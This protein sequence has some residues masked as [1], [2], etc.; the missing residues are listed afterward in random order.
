MAT[1]EPP[2]GGIQLRRMT[3]KIPLDQRHSDETLRATTA[4]QAFPSSTQQARSP[5]PGSPDH[6]QAG[7]QQTAEAGALE[8]E[9]EQI[10]P[11]GQN[12]ETDRYDSARQAGQG[13]GDKREDAGHNGG[14]LGRASMSVIT[15]PR[16]DTH[17]PPTSAAAQRGR[18]SL[19]STASWPDRLVAEVQTRPL[20]RLSEAR[21]APAAQQLAAHGPKRPADGAM[22][23]SPPGSAGR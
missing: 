18:L 10:D 6:G 5:L 11:F 22:L 17:R 9:A 21:F 14:A 16:A 8:H 7:G 3:V 12:I 19:K 13:D 1:T 23:R 15:G 2:R 20:E 4:P